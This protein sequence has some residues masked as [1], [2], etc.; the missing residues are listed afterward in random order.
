MADLAPSRSEADDRT[1][2]H[3]L[4][5]KGGGERAGTAI[6][7]RWLGNSAA[8]V[9]SMVKQQADAGSVTHSRY[10]AV[11]L[12]AQGEKAALARRRHHRLLETFLSEHQ[13]IPR[14]EVHAEADR[15]DAALDHPTADSHGAPIPAGVEE[16]D[17]ARLVS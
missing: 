11:A 5:R 3:H 4:P 1:A 14:H 7:A 10:Q 13:G 6:L 15:R 17:V 8:S 9:A 12:S 16:G 2:I